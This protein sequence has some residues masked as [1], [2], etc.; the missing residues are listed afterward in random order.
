MET[1]QQRDAEQWLVSEQQGHDDAAEAAF[2]RVFQALPRI[3]PRADFV[4]RV[5]MAT[6]VAERRRR[7]TQ[8][9]ARSAAVLLVALAGAAIGYG[10]VDMSGGWVAGEI[11][12]VVSHGLRGFIFIVRTGV[13]SWAVIA[14]IGSDVGTVL[15]TPQTTGAL[16]VME[17]IGMVAVL[18][19]RGLLPDQRGTVGSVE[20]RR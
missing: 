5:I 1:G 3:E 8:R 9:L 10:A 12:A 11:T 6:W 13:K 7:R 17:L 2:A 16:L 19:L 4:D 20:A 14:R 15:T 18:G